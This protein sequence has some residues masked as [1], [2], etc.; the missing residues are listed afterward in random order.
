MITR[1][2]K[3]YLNAGTNIAP[4]INANQFDQDE[5][6]IFTLLTEEGTVYTPST[7]AI[8]GLKT[9][10]TT[11][12]NAGTVNSS[13][14][15]VITETE[16]MTAV[17]GSNVFELLIDGNTHGTANF[18]VFVEKR[19]GDIDNPSESDISLFQEAI[20]AAGNVTQFQSDVENLQSDVSNLQ[21]DTGVLSNRIDQIV[22]DT[23]TNLSGLSVIT[24]RGSTTTGSYLFTIPASATI[25]D[26]SYA[27]TSG[28]TSVKRDNISYTT[29]ISGSNQLV[30][31]TVSGVSESCAIDLS[32]STVSNVS[33]P[34]LAD[35]RVGADGTTYPNAGDAVR[36][37]V[38]DLKNALGKKIDVIA[39][40][41]ILNVEDNNYTWELGT[42]N[43]GGSDV[44]ANTRI[45]MAQTN[46]LPVKKGDLVVYEGTNPNCLSGVFYNLSHSVDSTKGF[47]FDG[48]NQQ[49][50]LADGYFRLILRKNSNNDTI[51]SDEISGMVS[52]LKVYS[53]IKNA[54]DAIDAEVGEVNDKLDA[55]SGLETKTIEKY[56]ISANGTISSTNAYNVVCIRVTPGTVINSITIPSTSQQICYALYKNEPVAGSQSYDQ[57]RVTGTAYVDYSAENIYVPQNVNWIA[58]RV[59]GSDVPVIDTASAKSI[60]RLNKE[61]FI[62]S[63]VAMFTKVGAI[64]DSF[65]AGAIYESDQSSA[66]AN[67]PNSAWPA[68]MSRLNGNTVS[69][70]GASGATTATYLTREDGL[71]SVLSAEAQQLYVLCLGLNDKTQGITVGTADDIKE[72]YTQNPAT[73]CG[74]YGRIIDQIKAHAPNAK[75]IICKSFWVVENGLQP[76][77]YYSYSSDAIEAI[78]DHYGFPFIETMNDYFFCS[79]NYRSNWVN[80]HPTAPLYAG[81]A[82]RLTDLIGKCIIENVSYFASIK[83]S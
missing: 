30:N 44:S 34:E 46:Y 8:I 17:P 75:F 16:Q 29:S 72:D 69:N 31:V 27:L 56:G 70:F 50:V 82:K 64:G 7:G 83:L 1:E 9:D 65:T 4:V 81:M 57:S 77:D 26:I 25:L 3:L 78:A 39:D 49:T 76:S 32:Y 74:N 47:S 62:E 58:I 33:I 53:P 55:M 52:L 45:R 43:S 59:V 73:F 60:Q 40:G 20:T 13:G 18:V 22:V 14:Q 67:Y 6:W 35:I 41:Y 54:I 28:D 11:I 42:I 38:S 68:V 21:T 19:P 12:L 5:E 71:A 51:S 24:L 61:L 37:Q 80:Y 23:T 10:G 79:P 63:S 2:F 15:V 48:G 36:G 66:H